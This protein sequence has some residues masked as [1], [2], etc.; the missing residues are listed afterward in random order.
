M[1]SPMRIANLIFVQAI[2]LAKEA[3]RLPSIDSFVYISAADIMPFINPRYISTK[4]QAEQF[5]FSRDEFRTIVFRPG[6]VNNTR[7]TLASQ[8]T[9][10]GIQDSCTEK[11]D[12]L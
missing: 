5:L 6:G 9:S 1:P 7:N 11:I 2:T 10:T 12:R 3:A 8:L 4:R